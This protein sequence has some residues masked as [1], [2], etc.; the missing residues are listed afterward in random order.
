[1]R[2]SDEIPEKVKANSYFAQEQPRLLP[3]FRH[4]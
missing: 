1:M 2:G 4:L 3:Q